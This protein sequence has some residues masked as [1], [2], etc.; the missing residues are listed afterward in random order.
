MPA[1]QVTEVHLLLLQSV[2]F[3]QAG[4]ELMK[5]KEAEPKHQNVTIRLSDEMVG[6]LD[7]RAAEEHR[8][9]ANFIKLLLERS[10]EAGA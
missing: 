2:W 10:K 8:S 7:K 6:W 1:L 9:R 5:K 4:G 3:N